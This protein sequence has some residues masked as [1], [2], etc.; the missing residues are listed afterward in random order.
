[1]FV[2]IWQSFFIFTPRA[3]YQLQLARI[4]ESF[5]REGQIRAEVILTFYHKVTVTIFSHAHPEDEKIEDAHTME[6]LA[7]LN[8]TFPY[9]SLFS[10]GNSLS[11][12]GYRSYV[13]PCR[14]P[15]P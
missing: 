7:L 5:P 4:V 9:T 14:C 11:G 13:S 6:F 2:L 8:V 12:H 3:P 1:M 10:D 15:P